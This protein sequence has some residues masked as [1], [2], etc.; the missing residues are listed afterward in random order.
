MIQAFLAFLTLQLGASLV[1][2]VRLPPEENVP[3]AAGQEQ[4]AMP[5]SAW[6]DSHN[7]P[8]PPPERL[9]RDMPSPLPAR[10][11]VTPSNRGRYVGRH[12]RGHMPVV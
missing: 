5:A 8:A 12:A 9:G 10:T 2:I 3:Q 4:P 6:S 11:G 1:A 7:V